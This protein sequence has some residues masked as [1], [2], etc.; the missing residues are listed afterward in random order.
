MLELLGLMFGLIWQFCKFAIV[1]WVCLFVP[2]VLFIVLSTFS[3][4]V[5]TFGWKE[6]VESAKKKLDKKIGRKTD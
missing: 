3:L 2:T 4:S 5:L 1:L 6:A